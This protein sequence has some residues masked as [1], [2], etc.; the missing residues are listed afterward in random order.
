MGWPEGPVLMVGND[1]DRDIC[2]AQMLGLAT[3]HVEDGSASSFG[4][5]AGG[6]GKLSDLRLLLDHTDLSTLIPSFK[7]KDSVLAV[8]AAAPAAIN[9]LSSGLDFSTWSHEPTMDDWALTEILCHLRDTEREIHHMQI[10]L[11]N[12]Q[13]EP[14]IPRPDTSIWAKQRNYLHEDG[15]SALR[16]FN[17]ARRET[18]SLLKGFADKDWGNKARHAIFGPTNFLEVV[19]F[20]AE[21]DRLHIHQTWSTLKKL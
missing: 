9:G 16:E 11:F 7:T 10:K 4:P 12:G 20:I 6:R 3:Y 14:F 2:P 17:D 18:M 15:V 13:T 21:H 1:M 8:L 5:G 19:G